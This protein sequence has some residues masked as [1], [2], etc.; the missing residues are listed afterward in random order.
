[1]L[2]AWRYLV[3]AEA[4]AAPG[5]ELWDVELSISANAIS[6]KTSVAIAVPLGTRFLRRV[7]QTISHPGWRQ[8]F[9]PPKDGGSLRRIN[10]IASMDGKLSVQAVFSLHASATPRLVTEGAATPLDSEKRESYL[11]DHPLLQIEHEEVTRLIT[12]LIQGV[13]SEGLLPDAIYEYVRQLRERAA[14]TLLEVPDVL[15]TN[16]ANQRERAYTMV[17]LCRAAR[18]PARLVKGIILRETPVAALHYWVEVYQS[19]RW[20]PFDPVFGYRDT[21][22]PNYLPFVKGINDV[23]GFSGTSEYS[24][25]YAI[26]NADPLLDVAESTHQDWREMLELTRLPLDTRI[27]LAALML[28]P[29]GVLLTAVCSEMLG[30]RCYGVFTPV[31]LAMSL[32]YVP[33]QSGAVILVIVLAVGVLGRSAIPGELSRIPR[34]SVVLTLVALGIGA[35][36]SLMDYFNISF[37]GQL[38]LLPIVILASLVDRFYSTLDDRG[39]RSALFR[40]GWTLVIALLCVPIVQ[41]EALGHALVRF[42]ELHLVTLAA[43]LSLMLYKGR[44]LSQL[45]AFAWLDSSQ[46][47]RPKT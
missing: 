31:L 2:A 40:L 28:L 37:G 7:G 33:W 10:L 39:L 44:R 43:I 23:V 11:R 46:E 47:P 6:E 5:D 42:P 24:V 4:A 8:T 21:M 19:G 32:T 38:V 1:M 14:G 16:Q 41:F 35:S 30:I 9:Q 26:A 12:Q 29:F 15:T 22:P 27:M 17:S 18:I 45:P 25:E 13:A 20:L 3:T 36:A 34:L